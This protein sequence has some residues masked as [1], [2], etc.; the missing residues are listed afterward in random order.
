MFFVLKDQGCP[1]KQ[2]PYVCLTLIAINI[3]VYLTQLSDSS[4]FVSS[5]AMIPYEIVN[6]V[7]LI[8]F[9]EVTNGETTVKQEYKAAP[10]HPRFTLLTSLFMHADFFHLFGNM[11]YLWIFGD[12]IEHVLGKVRFLAFY[13]LGGILAS[14]AHILLAPASITPMLG[15]SGALAAVLGAYLLLFPKNRLLVVVYF[16]VSVQATWLVLGVWFLFQLIG[17]L[18]GSNQGIAFAAHIGGF[19]YGMHAIKYFIKLVPENERTTC[20]LKSNT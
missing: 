20:C 10:I 13:L 1:N 11:F 6:G 9:I 5:A 4:K 16:W 14:F 15:A 18:F 19:I 2:V 7:D 17:Q 8:G 12:Q 3:L